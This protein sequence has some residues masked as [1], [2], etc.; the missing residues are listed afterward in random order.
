MFLNLLAF[1]ITD[2]QA[3]I[4]IAHYL[5]CS[6]MICGDVAYVLD[7]ASTEDISI[8]WCWRWEDIDQDG[9]RQNLGTAEFWGIVI[10]FQREQLWRDF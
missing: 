9:W 6:F 5:G 1:S 7:F 2:L 3:F 4:T 8:L 10:L